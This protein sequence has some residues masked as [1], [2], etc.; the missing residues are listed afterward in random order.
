MINEESVGN[1]QGIFGWRS[2][3]G[4]HRELTGKS[5]FQFVGNSLSFSMGKCPG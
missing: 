3:M 1:Q 4:I 5:R 2:N